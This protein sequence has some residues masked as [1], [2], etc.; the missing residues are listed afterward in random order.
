MGM[1]VYVIGVCIFRLVIYYVHIKE[2]L[3]ENKK[4]L[5]PTE[6]DSAMMT[7]TSIMWPLF[8]PMLIVWLAYNMTIGRLERAMENYFSQQASDQEDEKTK[9]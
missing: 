8:L 3:I 7:S 2:C 4:V 5:R 6:A 9:S 1:V